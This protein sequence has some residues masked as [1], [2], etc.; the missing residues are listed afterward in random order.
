MKYVYIAL[1]VVFAGI[2]LLFKVQNL[3]SVTVSLFAASVTLPVSILVLLVYV[4]GML[5]GGMVLA[6]LRA[7]IHRA[8]AQ[9]R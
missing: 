3:T 5:T 6:L 7:L 4:M 2:V 9:N 1:I 8:S